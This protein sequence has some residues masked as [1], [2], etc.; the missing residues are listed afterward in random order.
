METTTTPQPTPAMRARQSTALLLAVMTTT[1]GCSSRSHLRS[2]SPSA[3]PSNESGLRYYAPMD[4][5]R[6]EATATYNASRGWHKLTDNTHLC[7]PGDKPKLLK[8][9]TTTID[10]VTVPDRRVAYHLVM[11][12]AGSAAQNL[13]LAVSNDGLLSSMS[14]SV[15]DKRAEIA[16]NVL[17]SVAGIAGTVIGV[18]NIIG[19]GFMAAG[20]GNQPKPRDRGEECALRDTDGKALMSRLLLTRDTLEAGL[21]KAQREREE[22]LKHITS[23]KDANALKLLEARDDLHVKRIAVLDARLAT[24]RDA[25]ANRVATFKADSAIAL[26]DTIVKVDAVV[27]L[28]QLPDDSVVAGKLGSVSA[29]SAALDS[30]PYARRLLDSARVVVTV[31]EVVPPKPRKV[32][33]ASTNWQQNDCRASDPTDSCVHIYSRAPRP[34]VVR[35]YVPTGGTPDKAF[36]LKE[37]RVI[38]AISS[39]D[40]VL[41]IPVSTRTLGQ[42]T[43]AMTFGRP[44][45]LTGFEQTSTAGLATATST[46][47]TALAS[48]RDEFTA[49]L[50][51]AQKTQSTLLAMD[52]EART[53]RIKDL[54]DQKSLVEAQ[55]ALQGTTTSKDLVAQKQTLDAQLALLTAQQSL[56][57]AQQSASTNADLAAMRAEVQRLQTQIEL[58]KMQIELE[59]TKKLAGTQ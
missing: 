7:Q 31:A 27:D 38:S 24:V 52:S 44:G 51:T 54:Q 33:T 43:F 57:N 50:T 35:I 1:V 6:V 22:N 36:A 16:G 37:S 9:V 42:Q 11:K 5:I 56:V 29:A 2:L 41:D 49:G 46:I 48:A 59:K 30:F 17:K 32:S 40:S 34:R 55:L 19:G 47:A 15:E 58:L 26:K 53:S 14:Y 25:I 39:A 20:L 28:T 8:S 10:Q 23:A 12:P 21:G 4:V 3:E 18:D 13:K 45:T